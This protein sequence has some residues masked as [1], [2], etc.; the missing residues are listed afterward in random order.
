MCISQQLS[1][2]ALVRAGLLIVREEVRLSQRIVQVNREFAV[3][4]GDLHD[5]LLLSDEFRVCG[6]CESQQQQQNRPA[7]AGDSHLLPP[8]VVQA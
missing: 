3:I 4:F 6:N 7:V 1:V 8:K 5:V 2:F